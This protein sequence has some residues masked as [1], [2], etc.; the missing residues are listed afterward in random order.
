MVHEMNVQLCGRVLQKPTMESE[1]IIH[2]V[3]AEAATKISYNLSNALSTPCT[4]PG[5]VFFMCWL[6]ECVCREGKGGA[7]SGNAKL[8]AGIMMSAL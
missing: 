7:K 8:A 5:G 2:S 4:D 1:C 6:C 3:P